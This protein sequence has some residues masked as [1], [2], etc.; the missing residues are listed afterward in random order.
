MIAEIA[1]SI[2]LTLVKSPSNTPRQ[3]A[4]KWSSALAVPEDL[5]PCQLEFF[6]NCTAR[7]LRRLWT[8]VMQYL[9]KRSSL[10]GSMSDTPK[11]EDSSR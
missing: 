9:Q 2:S 8:Q 1:G 10:V 5:F 6:L 7:G 3:L 11:V 4:A